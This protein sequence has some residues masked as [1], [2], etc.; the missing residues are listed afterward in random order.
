MVGV[1][2]NK[3]DVTKSGYHYGYGYGYGYGDYGYYGV[4]DNA[5]EQIADARGEGAHVS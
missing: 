4:R 1:V 3:L 2:I 5:T